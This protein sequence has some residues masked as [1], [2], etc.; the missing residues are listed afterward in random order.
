ME[1]STKRK[2]QFFLSSRGICFGD[3]TTG[4]A[5]TEIGYLFVLLAGWGLYW[6]AGK[7]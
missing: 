3:R 1:T 2:W 4:E 7:L 5:H 6:L